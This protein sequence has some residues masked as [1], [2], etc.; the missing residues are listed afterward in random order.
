MLV[1]IAVLPM[2]LPVHSYWVAL[3]G[4]LRRGSPALALQL[5]PP[6]MH[7]PRPSVAALR[8]RTPAK[9]ARAWH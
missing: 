3:A 4:G 9:H 7:T 6:I 8:P 5:P 1:A 2:Q